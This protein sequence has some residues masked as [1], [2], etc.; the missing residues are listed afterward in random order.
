[1]AALQAQRK[2]SWD[3]RFN[4]YLAI[5]TAV[6]RHFLC[7][8]T[9]TNSVRFKPSVHSPQASKLPP[10]P[11][12]TPEPEPSD[13]YTTIY[14]EAKPNVSIQPGDRPEGPS[15]YCQLLLSV[16]INPTT[17]QRGAEA[18]SS[19]YYLLES[20][21]TLSGSNRQREGITTQ[22]KDIPSRPFI[23]LQTEPD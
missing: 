15:S 12:S 9:T 10:T 22:S 16:R 8:Q 13:L 5:H 18:L 6:I 21:T 14:S 17:Q 2:P 23:Y 1:M 4:P 3:A 19:D 20:A 11:R 7:S